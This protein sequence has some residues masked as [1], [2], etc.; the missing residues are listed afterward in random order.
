MKKF[1]PGLIIAAVA[2]PVVVWLFY[3]IAIFVSK[4]DF[5]N[6]AA[7]LPAFIMPMLWAYIAY[8]CGK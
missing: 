1:I 7:V 5:T 8:D 2:S 3:M 6:A 4:G